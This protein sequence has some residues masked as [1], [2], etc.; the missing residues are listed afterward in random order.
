MHKAKLFVGTSG[1]AYKDWKGVFYPPEVK[2]QSFLNYY[3][4]QFKAVEVDA[5]FYGIPRLTT[6]VK[7][8]NQ[9]PNSF[10]FSLKVPKIITHEKRLQNCQS[11]WQ[12]FLETTAQ[13]EHKR[14]PLILQFDYRFTFE[15]FF[16][17]LDA[18]LAQPRDNVQL[19]V[20]VRN[21]SWY[22]EAFFQ[23]LTEHQVA[24]VLND[25][26]YSPR[27]VR[28]TT[29]FTLIRLLGNHKQISNNFSK[30]RLSRR[31]DLNWWAEQIQALLETSREVFVFANNHYQGHAPPTV[32]N[33]LQLLEAKSIQF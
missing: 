26:Y 11:E 10:V 29:E 25:L 3:S 16:S 32:N 30:A 14:G 15:E 27:V 23:M 9:T 22:K 19:A 33:L 5:T 21:K 2:T 31:A 24:L 13:L 20:E 18:F 17:T 28:Q 7:W 6:V 4:Q 8:F 12:R 1:W